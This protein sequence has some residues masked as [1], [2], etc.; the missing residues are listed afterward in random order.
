MKKI[1]ILGAVL[2]HP[3]ASQ[4]LFNTI[5]SSYKH[6]IKGRMGVPFDDEEI[7]VVSI[8]VMGDLNDIN[9]LTG[10]LGNIPGVVVKTSISKK[11]L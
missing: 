11:E 4:E 10:K 9:A 3:E 8:T 1:A 7:S 2:D 5:L 6:I